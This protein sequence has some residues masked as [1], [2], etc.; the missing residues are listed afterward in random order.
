MSLV[1]ILLLGKPTVLLWHMRTHDNHHG[2]C[3]DVDTAYDA[4]NLTICLIVKEWTGTARPSVTPS[5]KSSN[6]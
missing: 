1:T 2:L 4:E 6:R 3:M 5:N